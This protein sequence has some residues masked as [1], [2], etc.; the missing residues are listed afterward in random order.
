M[1]CILSILQYHL[2]PLDAHSMFSFEYIHIYDIEIRN[3]I[4]LYIH[5]IYVQRKIFKCQIKNNSMK[6]NLIVENKYFLSSISN[7]NIT[8]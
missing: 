6:L 8:I 3:R 7:D 2:T 1:L 4:S 5:L